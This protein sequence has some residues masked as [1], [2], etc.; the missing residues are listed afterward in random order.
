MKQWGRE[1]RFREKKR[2]GKVARARHPPEPA[3]MP[4]WLRIRMPREIP[5]PRMWKQTWR[6]LNLPLA[7]RQ[8]VG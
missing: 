7:S 4:P 6:R 8:A 1:I 5:D 2:I 3:E